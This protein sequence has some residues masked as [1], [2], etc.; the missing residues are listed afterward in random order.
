MTKLGVVG[1]MWSVV[2]MANGTTAWAVPATGAMPGAAHYEPAESERM[3]RAMD[4]IIDEQWF[5]AIK[6]LRL[7]ADDPKEPARDGALFWLAHSQNQVG[8]LSSAIESLRRLQRDFTKT[9]YSKPA[10]S[11]LIE[12]AQKLGRSDVLWQMAPPPPPPPPQPAPA[13]AALPD[14]RGAPRRP[15]PPSPPPMPVGAPAPTAVPAPPAPPKEPPMPWITETVVEDADIRILALGRLIRTDA[16]KVIPMLGTIALTQDKP[17]EARRAVFVLAQS[18]HP[19]AQLVVVD[20]AKKGS[21]AVRLAAV[22]ELGRFGGPEIGKELLQVY[23]TA[24]LPVKQQVVFSL[25]QR[26]DATAL[27]KIAQSENNPDLRENAVLALGRAGARDQLRVM[28]ANA[29]L[30]VRYVIVRGLFTARDDD[31]LIRI[32]EEEKEPRLRS[33]AND[34]L[35]L[36]NTPRARAYLVEKAK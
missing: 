11:L 23:S 18:G 36:M 7:A 30:E 6:E 31:G 17:A 9:R 26:N 24:D 15:V 5:A 29:P 32:C 34:R 33:Y 28:Y 4:L 35:R 21:Q 12:L 25:S 1:V 14:K 8:D 3:I 13:A 19:D 22:K 20:V 27:L 16:Q 10:A 2:L